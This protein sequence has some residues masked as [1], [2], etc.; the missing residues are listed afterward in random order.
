MTPSANPTAPESLDP[1]P[2]NERHDSLDD[3]R[4]VAVLG[5]LLM[6]AVAIALPMSAYFNPEIAGGSRGANLVFWVLQF[7]LWDGK[8]RAIF[9]M[10]FGAGL[11]CSTDSRWIQSYIS[12][13][14]GELGLS[15]SCSARTRSRSEKGNTH[16]CYYTPLHAHR[17]GQ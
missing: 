1:T 10:M 14:R 6:N 11:V 7:V 8:M 17:H 4:G 9:C 15:S 3:L 12:L 13:L 16:G 2:L 5:I